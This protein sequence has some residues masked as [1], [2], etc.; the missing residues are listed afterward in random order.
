MPGERKA[1]GDGD[2][3]VGDNKP[4]KPLGDGNKN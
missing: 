3:G 2:L 1:Y 4:K